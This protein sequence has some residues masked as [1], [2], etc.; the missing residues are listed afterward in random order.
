MKT[1]GF[2]LIELLIVVAIIAILAAIAVP[3]FLEAQTRS[4][5]SRAKAD[6]RNMTTAVE[7]YKIDEGRYPSEAPWH[8]W[9]AD[10]SDRAGLGLLTSPVAYITSVPPD[11]FGGIY[12]H[13]YKGFYATNSPARWYWY[14]DYWHAA[15]YFNPTGQTIGRAYKTRETMPGGDY[16]SAMSLGPS[17]VWYP[18]YP[19][20]DPDGRQVQYDPTNGTVSF[21]T[22]AAFGPGGGIK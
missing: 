17:M 16:W 8:E 11:I 3:N 13:L 2:T 18:N 20:G 5:I 12:A 15:D 4:K 14:K 19:S 1:K 21:G 22:I 10:V 7:M 9:G 6:L